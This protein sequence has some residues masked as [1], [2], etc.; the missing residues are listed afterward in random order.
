[1]KDEAIEIN[2]PDFEVLKI[3]KPTGDII[4]EL[5]E[6]RMEVLGEKLREEGFNDWKIHKIFEILSEMGVEIK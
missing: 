5:T 2:V 1:M 6:F 3:K 4:I